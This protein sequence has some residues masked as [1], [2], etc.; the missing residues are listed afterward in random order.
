M[1]TVDETFRIALDHHRAG[2]LE[3]AE[4]L[5]SQILQASPRQLDALY[6]MGFAQQMQGKFPEAIVTYRRRIEAAPGFALAHAKLGEVNLWLGRLGTAVDHYRDALALEPGN[7]AF[8]ESL[9]QV[10]DLLQTRQKSLDLYREKGKFDLRDVTFL[11]PFRLDTDDRRRNIKIIVSYLFKHFETNVLICEDQPG[12]SN[13][14]KIAEE[15]ALPPGA[16]RLLHVTGNDTPFT[17][18]GKQINMLAEAAQTP[19]VVGY[20]TDVIV[21]PVQYLYGR[22]AIL[23]GALMACPFNGLFFDVS[24][25][26]VPAVERHLSVAPI[27]LLDPRNPLLYKN[28]YSGAVFFDR[29][30]FL[31]LGG[32]NER[33]VS[34]GWEDFELYQRFVKLEQRIERLWGPLYHLSHARPPNSLKVHPFYEANVQEF[35]RV[36]AMSKAEILEAIA[37]GTFK[38]PYVSSA[39]LAPSLAQ[40]GPA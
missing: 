1:P 21:D 31:E 11:I 8:Q 16:C 28:S 32:F 2:R 33:F 6:N 4:A 36:M 37:S 7:A 26:V 20:D 34:W 18:R 15:L 35:E 29:A 3:E 25:E 40:A 38:R 24:P 13:F 12:E 27:D 17:H 5:Y 10:L 9:K 39:D 14:R 19:I 30:R 22:S 23:D